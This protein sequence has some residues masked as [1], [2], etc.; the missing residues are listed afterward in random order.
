MED[1]IREAAALKVHVPDA[2]RGCDD[3]ELKRKAYELLIVEAKDD[4]RDVSREIHQALLE[5]SRR[6]IA[7]RE[8][9]EASQRVERVKTTYEWLR[10]R[11]RRAQHPTSEQT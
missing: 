1:L 8:R 3:D 10:Q 7:R 9:D 2:V 4:G 5:C 11:R 6:W